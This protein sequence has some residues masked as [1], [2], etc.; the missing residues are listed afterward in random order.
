MEHSGFDYDGL[1]RMLRYYQA[2]GVP[3]IVSTAGGDYDV[4]ARACDMGANAIQPAWMRSA[5]N[6]AR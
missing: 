3:A 5:P 1:K 6:A 2:A 4:I